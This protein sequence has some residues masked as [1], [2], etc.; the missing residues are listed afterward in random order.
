[1][2]YLNHLAEWCARRS[3]SL[4][5]RARSVSSRFNFSIW[6]LR[7]E[8]GIGRQRPV[9]ATTR[10]SR[11]AINVAFSASISLGRYVDLS[12]NRSRSQNPLL[13][14]AEGRGV[15]KEPIDAASCRLPRRASSSVTS[16]GRPKGTFPGPGELPV[17]A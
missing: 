12:T 17:R 4:P 16:C 9:W 13:V 7:C 1:M 15:N 8:P 10:L 5:F 2:T 11:S 14:A 6:S 3:Y